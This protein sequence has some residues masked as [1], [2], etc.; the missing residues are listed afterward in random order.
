MGISLTQAL[1][2]AG[3][4]NYTTSKLP[5]KADCELKGANLSLE[6]VNCFVGLHC[7]AQ[8]M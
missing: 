5:R 1:F 3:D 2:D 8:V 6:G 4:A 7:I